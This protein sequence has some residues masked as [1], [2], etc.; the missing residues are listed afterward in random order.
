MATKF[1]LPVASTQERRQVRHDINED[2]KSEKLRTMYL[3][4]MMFLSIASPILYE[5]SL[6]VW[7]INL[8]CTVT[9][10]VTVVRKHP[11][12]IKKYSEEGPP[13]NQIELLKRVSQSTM[14][15]ELAFMGRPTS[16]ISTA[17]SDIDLDEGN[18]TARLVGARLLSHYQ[19]DSRESMEFLDELRLHTQDHFTDSLEASDNSL[20]GHYSTTGSAFYDHT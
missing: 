8:L 13:F 18:S 5:S 6:I 3:Y 9:L 16:I 4:T 2:K 7:F 19:E 14:D 17:T 10:M 12:E 1:N 20:I 11:E 15:H